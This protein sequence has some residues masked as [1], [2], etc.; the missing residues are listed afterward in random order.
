MMNQI[1]DMAKSLIDVVEHDSDP[2]VRTTAA[3]AAASLLHELRDAGIAS[4]DSGAT[5]AINPQTLI[6][7][8]GKV[9]KRDPSARLGLLVSYRRLGPVDEP[10][11]EALLAA[12]D[13]SSRVVRI[14]ALLA[15]AEFTSGVDKA[16]SVLLSD[17]GS[18]P[19][20]SQFNRWQHLYPL[21]QAAER[22]P[23]SPAV[24]PLLIDG[25]RSPSPDVREVAVVILRHLGP[26]ARPAAQALIS[27][28]RSMIRSV[29]HAP[30]QGEDPFFSDF[31]STTVQ[32]APTEDAIAVLSEAL[33]REHP[34]CGAHA[35]YF[36]GSL[37]PRGA[38][39]FRSCLK[40]S[41]TSVI[42]PA[43]GCWRN[44]RTRS[45]GRSRQSLRAP[46]C[47]SRRPTR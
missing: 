42:P 34:A 46:G 4:H 40:L 28:T 41:K 37:G 45:C 7:V 23:V 26:A 31:A 20:E 10:A 18:A 12:L 44:M 24:I 11:P 22:L 33:D 39:R 9:L 38:R 16:A 19:G 36:L 27:A 5:D 17:A 13:D 3:F 8:L 35:A 32:I 47:P 25:L 21:R 15:L 14:E 30:E 1:R 2:A 6:K 29:K 43:A